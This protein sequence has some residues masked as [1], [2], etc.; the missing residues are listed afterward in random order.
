MIKFERPCF[1]IN[2]K[3]LDEK[4]SHLKE[5]HCKSYDL[6]TGWMQSIYKI[7]IESQRHTQISKK[8]I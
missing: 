8:L 2:N 4:K 3:A 1:G 5:M 7:F 6:K